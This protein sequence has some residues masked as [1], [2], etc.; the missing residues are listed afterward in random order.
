MDRA[1]GRVGEVPLR[2]HATLRVFPPICGA[3][4]D[5]PGAAY[6]AP[7]FVAC[8]LEHVNICCNT[9]GKPLHLSAN[10]C[11]LRSGK[12]LGFMRVCVELSVNMRLPRF[13][14]L[15]GSSPACGI[16]KTPYLRGFFSF[17]FN[18][19]FN[20]LKS[21]QNIPQP[22]PHIRAPGRSWPGGISRSSLARFS[23]L[24][25]SGCIHPERPARAG[26]RQ[27]MP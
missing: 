6:T 3:S 25:P 10:Y 21:C 13:R 26:L 5:G 23:I 22:S 12:L 15:S 4:I 20:T 11:I 7:F 1:R 16:R 19:R 24:R 18:K 9:F 14:A 8:V 27:S 17:R 2:D